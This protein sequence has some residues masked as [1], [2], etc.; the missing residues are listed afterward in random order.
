MKPI[1]HWPLGLFVAILF[2][3]SFQTPP[4]SLTEILASA[5]WTQTESWTDLDE[6]ET[7]TYNT[8]ACMSDDRWIFSADS[9]LLYLDDSLKCFEGQAGYDTIT[10]QWALLA[11]E[12]LLALVAGNGVHYSLFEIFSVGLNEIVMYHLSPVDTM[13]TRHEKVV[14]SR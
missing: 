4:P 9:T 2:F 11:D 7:F 3:S 10:Y 1:I 6:D 5:P 13:G 14:I 12:T 8:P